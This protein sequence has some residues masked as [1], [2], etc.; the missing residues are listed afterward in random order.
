[1]RREYKPL[2]TSSR[3]LRSG[4]SMECIRA[5]TAVPLPNGATEGMIFRR[6][7]QCQHRLH[8]RQ[9]YQGKWRQTCSSASLT[10]ARF[11]N[12]RRCSIVAN[13]SEVGDRGAAPRITLEIPGNSIL[14]QYWT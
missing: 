13:S 2:T 6:P 8:R 5:L 4:S 11:S 9:K 10:L 12:F 14:Y 7:H 1:M 3:H